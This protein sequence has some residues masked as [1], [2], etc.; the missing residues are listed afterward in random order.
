MRG[1]RGLRRL[2]SSL[3][4]RLFEIITPG[5]SEGRTKRRRIKPIKANDLHALRETPL[6]GTPCIS[7]TDPSSHPSFPAPFHG[8][9]SRRS[10]ST[11]SHCETPTQGGSVRFPSGT[12][13]C[14][15]R[16]G[17]FH[18][19]PSSWRGETGPSAYLLRRALYCLHFYGY[20]IFLSFRGSRPGLFRKAHNIC[21][22]W[23]AM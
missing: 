17:T 1:S 4:S 3:I 21:A 6:V 15:N 7:G 22:C 8:I 11:V 13:Q 14:L 5:G 18:P 12:P 9:S 20:G 16:A 19:G 2:N 23:Y 10:I